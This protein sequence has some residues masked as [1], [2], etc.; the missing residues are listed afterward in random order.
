MKEMKFSFIIGTMNRS[1]E[2]ECCLRSLISQTYENYEIVVVDQSENDKTSQIIEK[3]DSK[4]IKYRHVAF[5]GLSKARNLALDLAQGDYICLTDDDARYDN[6]Y[7]ENL[8]NHY[9]NDATLIISG[10]LWDA[11]NK[12]SFVDYEKLPENRCL[13]TRQIFRYCPSPAITFPYEVFKKI[14]YFDENFGV[15][16]KYG[17]GEET[18]YLLRACSSGYR[19]IHFKD[20]SAVHPHEK[21]NAAV[22]E[23]AKK[24]KAYNYPFGTGALYRK[25]WNNHNKI[26]LLFFEQLLRN[27]LKIVLN[28]DYSKITFKRFI[29][30]YLDYKYL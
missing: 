18:D 26:I 10:V 27:V 8:C 30:G 4:K 14:G 6:D 17:A 5:K 15:G 28:K 20:V 2:I 22:D 29:E 3:I 12:R 9:K 16:A 7:L 11:I 23:R 21:A 24:R 1:T 13:N 19:V 25:H